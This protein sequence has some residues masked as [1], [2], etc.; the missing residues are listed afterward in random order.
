MSL[1]S[2]GAHRDDDDELKLLHNAGTKPADSPLSEME[3]M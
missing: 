2:S 3:Q 1:P